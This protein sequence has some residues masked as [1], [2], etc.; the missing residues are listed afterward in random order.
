M[1]SNMTGLV[2]PREM[3]EI[4]AKLS[5][6]SECSVCSVDEDIS[7]QRGNIFRYFSLFSMLL[8]LVCLY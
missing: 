7:S 5:K 1:F 3:N 4:Y 6:I 2:K 8:E